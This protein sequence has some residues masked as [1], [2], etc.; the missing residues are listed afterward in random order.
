MVQSIAAK[1]VTLAQLRESFGLQ[2]ARDP[3]FFTEWMQPAVTLTPAEEQTLDR[4]KQ[5]FESLMEDPPM[6]ENTVKMVVLS[7]LLD[8]AGFYRSPYAIETEPSIELTATDG[9]T[10]V[11]GRI[12]VLVLQ[13]HFWLLV[14]ESKRSD[15]SV[16]RGLPQALSYMLANPAKDKPSFGLIMNGN[17]F[18][19]VKAIA[20]P[21]AQY[22][23]SRLFSLINP[24]NELQDIL[25]IM[26]GL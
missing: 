1:E 25:K 16:T 15:F 5:N 9:D 6:L 19:F 14:I 13:R 11:R 22:A 2:V 8:L 24:G 21:T 20:H 18:L 17:E 12:D 7:P 3:Q 26:K 10:T 23:T 4:V